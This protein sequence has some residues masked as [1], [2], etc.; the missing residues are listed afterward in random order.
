MFLMFVLTLAGGLCC[1]WFIYPIL[2]WSFLLAFLP[3]SYMHF[4]SP[5]FEMGRP[6]NTNEE[7]EE[8][9]YDIG[10]KARRKETTRKTK[11]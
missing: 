8:R 10:G 7:E 11:T 6:C 4:S 9:I 5:P 2:L 3:I 1:A